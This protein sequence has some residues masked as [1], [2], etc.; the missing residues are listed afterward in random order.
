MEIFKYNAERVQN[1][2]IF[3]KKL[4][5]LKD[6][7]EKVKLFKEFETEI[8]NL[9]P[10]DI[11]YL[12]F[13][14][15]DSE[16]SI[17]EIK[18]SANKFVNVF[19]KGIFK[20]SN[21][22]EHPLFVQLLKENKSIQNH[23]SLIKP[24]YKR[25]EILNHKKELKTIFKKCNDFEL[26]FNKYE[27][28]IFSYLEKRVPSTKPLEVLWELHDDSKH[29]LKS[30]LDLLETN[31]EEEIILLP[32]LKQ[33]FKEEELNK[34]YNECLEVGFVFNKDKLEPIRSKSTMNINGYF[35]SK[36]G[37]MS[38]DQLIQMLNHLP[39]DITFVDKDDVVLYYN[40]NLNRHFPRTPAVIGRQVK[41]CHPPKSVDVVEGIISDFKSNKKDF[42]EFWIN[43]KEK[44]LYIAYYAVRDEKSNY[45]GVLEVSQDITRFQKLTGEKRLRD[46]Q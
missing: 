43:F 9:N 24:F 7:S 15:N 45:I 19:H 25:G 18:E 20:H 40:D 41:N 32:V 1:I 30:I 16:L 6:S 26:K 37:K 13:Y 21:F 42:E 38:I 12:D 8:E 17:K 28:I 5:E 14:S 11:F 3:M 4:L 22:G 2:N 35:N 36:T 27:N 44:L 46:H 39:M 31:D 29:L 34:I 33:L 23:L 10:L